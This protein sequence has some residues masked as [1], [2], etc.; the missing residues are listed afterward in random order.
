MCRFHRGVLSL[1]AALAAAVLV[2]CASRAD[3]GPITI[4]F[5]GTVDAVDAGLAG[6]FSIGDS[7]TG[8][9]T[10]E[11]TTAPRAGSTSTFA[12]FDALLSLDFTLAAY[13]ASSTGAPEIQIDNDPGAPFFDRYAV[14]SRASDGLTGPTVSG[15]AL[16]FFGFR[17]DDSTNTVFSDALILPT[18]LNLSDFDNRRFFVFFGDITAPSV[19]SGTITSINSSAV[20]EPASALLL[21]VGALGSLAFGRR[22][23]RCTAADVAH[24]LA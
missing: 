21:G 10:F 14:V 24:H 20:P 23:R 7:L 2:A 5:T 12:V 19:V 3:A 18:N 9:Y 13:S 16:N 15:M 4:S 17:L 1:P 8:N 6:T 11:S 22:R